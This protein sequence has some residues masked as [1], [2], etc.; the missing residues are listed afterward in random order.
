[1]LLQPHTCHGLAAPHYCCSWCRTPRPVSAVL[2]GHCRPCSFRCFP[3][4]LL[5]IATLPCPAL[6]CPDLPFSS[7]PLHQQ[8]CFA[9][10]CASYFAPTL[11]LLLLCY[12][13]APALIPPVALAHE[14]PFES[15]AYTSYL[16]RSVSTWPLIHSLAAC[17]LPC[18]VARRWRR[19]RSDWPPL[20][21]PSIVSA[22]LRLAQ[23]LYDS[24]VQHLSSGRP[25]PFSKRPPPVGLNTLSASHRGDEQQGDSRPPCCL[26]CVQASARS[27][28]HAWRIQTL[29]A[30]LPHSV[31]DCPLS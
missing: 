9:L 24:S 21:A 6:P 26:A 13:C 18:A 4:I 15:V 22:V 27:A 25:Q 20:L 29:G 14:R 28:R 7:L 8:F 19:R 12:R 23:A 31:P 2:T 16:A 3:A 11:V 10:R 1:M 5:L 17:L 30:A